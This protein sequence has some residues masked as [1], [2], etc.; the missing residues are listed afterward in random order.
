MSNAGRLWRVL[1][2][3][4]AL[5]LVGWMLYAN[6][7]DLSRFLARDKHWGYLFAA[8]A[9]CGTATALTFVRW[10][11][12]VRAL[13]IPFRL[14]DAFRLGSMGLLFNYAGPGLV[15]GDMV[16]ALFIA[17][18]HPTRKAVAAATVLLDRVLG[19]QSLLLVGALAALAVRDLPEAWLHTAIFWLFWGGSLAGL[20]GLALLLQPVVTRSRLVAQFGRLPYVGH[21]A[22]DVLHGVTLYQSRPRVLCVAVL[23]GL[24]SH[25]CLIVGFYCCA[26]A[27]GGWAPSLLT[28]FYFMPAAEVV[29]LLPMPSGIGPLEWAISESYGAS[30]PPTISRQAAQAEGL[31]AAIA[32]RFVQMLIAAFGAIYYLPA[33][34]EIAVVLH[35]EDEAVKS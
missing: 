30:A 35:Q 33:R 24:A 19:L 2:W 11:V 8:C 10:H 15:G 29:G 13:G 7:Q 4:A 14:A 27:I 16:K 5:A 26:L 17:R 23:I 25:A 1:K 20:V 32:F 22:M 31:F 12:L 34:K 21:F 9:A 3:P 6:R 28:Q 18:E